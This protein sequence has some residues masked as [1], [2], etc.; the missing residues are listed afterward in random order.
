MPRPWWWHKP[1]PTT[2]EGLDR[3]RH[4]P[5]VHLKPVKTVFEFD[6][7]PI[8]RVRTCTGGSRRAFTGEVSVPMIKDVRAVPCHS[9]RR[10]LLRRERGRGRCARSMAACMPSHASASR[11]PCAT[12][13]AQG[14]VCAQVKAAFAGLMP[15]RPASASLHM[16]GAIGTGRTAT[17]EQAEEVRR[18]PRQLAV[19]CSAPRNAEEMRIL[20][21]AAP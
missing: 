18:H 4:V 10:G 12:R 21:T 3:R 7:Q 13:A 9:E 17:P 2:V 6:H 11:C 8:R 1:S 15:R 5:A 16:S 14:N 20:G 19:T